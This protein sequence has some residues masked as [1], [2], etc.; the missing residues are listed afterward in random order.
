MSLWKK[1]LINYQYMDG[2]IDTILY[3]AY[4]KTLIIN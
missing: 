2:I 1:M 4:I 3:V